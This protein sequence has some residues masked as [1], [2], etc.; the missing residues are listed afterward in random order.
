MNI[1]IKYKHNKK[2]I[3]NWTKYDEP[4]TSGYDVTDK[5]N[6]YLNM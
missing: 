6:E 5:F 4:G 2:I 1:Q 3:V